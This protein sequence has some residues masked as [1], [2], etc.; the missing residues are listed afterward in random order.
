MTHLIHVSAVVL[1]DP[2]GRVLLVRKRGTSMWM[3]PG[4]K[5]ERG[6]SSAECGAREVREELGLD[7]DPARLTPL[8]ELRAP[9]ANE[10]GHTVVSQCFAWPSP[11]SHDVRPAAEIDAVRWVTPGERGDTTLAPLFVEAIA[12]LLGPPWLG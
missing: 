11:I 2:E 12:P 8:G 3:N 7:L 10:P 9:A 5:P 1:T 6:E 4:G